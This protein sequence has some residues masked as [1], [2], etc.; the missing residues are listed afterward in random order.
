MNVQ[1]QGIAAKP[2]YHSSRYAVLIT[3]NHLRLTCLSENGGSQ[4][5]NINLINYVLLDAACLDNRYF[6]I[7]TGS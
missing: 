2:A 5:A 6:I 4:M 1:T 7:K 3:R